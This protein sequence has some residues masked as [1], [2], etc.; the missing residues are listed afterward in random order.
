MGAGD[1]SEHP[2]EHAQ[3]QNSAHHVEDQDD[4]RVAGEGGSHDSAAHDGGDEHGGSE[5]LGKQATHHRVTLSS[6]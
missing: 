1:R 3:S 5:V 2:N 6:I 4:G